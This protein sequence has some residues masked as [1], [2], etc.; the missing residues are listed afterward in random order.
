VHLSGLEP[1]VAFK[2]FS[3]FE[4]FSVSEALGF[5]DTELVASASATGEGVDVLAHD[6][7]SPSDR[8]ISFGRI[9]F[10]EGGPE[11]EWVRSVGGDSDDRLPMGSDFYALAELG[12]W[13]PHDD[14][15]WTRSEGEWSGGT[16]LATDG[17]ELW[18]FTAEVV[19][20]GA[21]LG[22]T[23]GLVNLHDLVP[24]PAHHIGFS[25]N[26]VLSGR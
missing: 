8:S 2:P 5:P 4:P 24:G 26:P 11:W 21:R 12:E 1:E 22:P 14:G 20:E 16:W 23:S 7:D 3:A 15:S 25:V 9:T 18:A 10:T 13:M 6:T 19:R 17:E